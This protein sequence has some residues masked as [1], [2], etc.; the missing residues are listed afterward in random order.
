LISTSC[1]PNFSF[2]FSSFQVSAFDFDVGFQLSLA[3]E[4]CP[5]FP[6]SPGSFQRF[7]FQP[8]ALILLDL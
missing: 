7:S 3:R 6:A 1:F 4:V 5:G 2:C 8:S